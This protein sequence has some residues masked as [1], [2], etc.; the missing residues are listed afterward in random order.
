MGSSSL[1]LARILGIRVGVHASWFFVLFL[2]IFLLS[3]NFTEKLDGNST[4]GYFVAVAASLLFFGSILLHELGHALAA[5]RVGIEVAGIDLFFFGGLMKMSRDTDS[6]GAELKVALAGPLVTLAIALVCSAAAIGLA[7]GWDT[8][9]DDVTLDRTTDAGIPELLVSFLASINLVLLAFNLIPA[10]PL[11]GGRVA[12]AI[13]WK[14]TGSRNRATRFSATIGR[15]FGYGLM[16]LGL[17]LAVTGTTVDGIWLLVLGWMLA[18]SAKAAVAQSVFSERIAHI[19]VAD[20][21]DADPVV[22]P[23]ELDAGRALDEFFMR[24]GYDWFP[25]TGS[26]GRPLGVAHHAAVRH[27]ASSGEAA[28]PVARL[29]AAHVGEAEI[30]QDVPI[31]ALLGSRPLR[32]R[33]ALLAVDSDG[34]LRG[35]VT[36]E[37]VARA[38]RRGLAPT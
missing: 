24:Y 17:A 9:V 28:L 16:A 7:G 22:I 19:T 21:M 14:V 26:D 31:E 8:F 6:P 27:A 37:Q 29:V 36:A 5:R 4:A 2:F 34:R 25:V 12:R 10:F 33:G 15:G 13:A 1:Q 11:D 3:G 35:V 23:G 30:R 18:Q 20:V 32:E 38:L